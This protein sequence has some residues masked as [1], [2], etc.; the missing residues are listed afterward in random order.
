MKNKFKSITT[1]ILVLVK[2]QLIIK[3]VT[4]VHSCTKYT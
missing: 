4:L 2:T 3:I 1:Q